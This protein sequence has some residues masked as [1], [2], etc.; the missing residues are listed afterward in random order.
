MK[1]VF[2]SRLP[3][4]GEV[5]ESLALSD[6]LLTALPPLRVT[7][8]L[9]LRG[10]KRLV[11]LHAGEWHTL[12]LQGCPSITSLPVITRSLRMLTLDGCG[13]EQ[14]PADLPFEDDAVLI[15]QNCHR[16]NRLPDAVSSGRLREIIVRNCP[17]LELPELSARR[18]IVIERMPVETLCVP[19]AAP[20]VIVSR[21]PRLR[22]VHSRIVAE[23]VSFRGCTAL[24]EFAPPE[25]DVSALSL[26]GCR[27]LTA[28]PE[29]LRFP[30]SF[31]QLDLDGCSRLTALP[32][33]LSVG[34]A[35]PQPLAV[36][37]LVV[38][39]EGCPLKQVPPYPFQWLIQIRGVRMEPAALLDPQGIDPSTVLRH[40]NAEVRRVLLENI[41]MET[42]LARTD[43]ALIDEDTD[44]GGCRRLIHFT[45][46]VRPPLPRGRFTRPAPAPDRLTGSAKLGHGFG[47]LLLKLFGR[48]QPPSSPPP[49]SP[50]LPPPAPGMEVLR[51]RHLECRCPST[52]RLYLLPVPPQIATCR[53]AAAWIAGFDNPNDYAPVLET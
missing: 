33:T 2:T 7:G 20:Q 52:G 51:C 4:E 5:R 25:G 47:R 46:P 44:P 43:H 40:P 38:L 45:L 41:G 24:E 1:S 22:S 27:S 11:T 35:N 10:M 36:A 37:V 49:Q 15:L 42:L 30:A 12:S 29:G 53:A 13:I 23:R 19:L 32:A 17:H 8:A 50:P 9:E 3:Q 28:L 31:S 34:P 48:R 6:P 16:L 21:C 18:R 39:A 26:H 14:L